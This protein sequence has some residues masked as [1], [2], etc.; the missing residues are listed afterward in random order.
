MFIN[1]FNQ[2][3]VGRWVQGLIDKNRL[4][5]FYVS[6]LWLRLRAEVLLE[7]KHECQ[8]CK[9]RGYYTRADTVHHVQYVKKHPG[10]ALS[11]VYVFGSKEIRN[12]VPLCHNC[13][14]MVHGYRVKKIEK[15]L[16]E[17]RW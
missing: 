5:D 3:E 1:I 16:T 10:L 4:H 17:E 13:H 11:K 7:Y 2:D 14:E 12:L 15:P 8:H 9:E 6:S